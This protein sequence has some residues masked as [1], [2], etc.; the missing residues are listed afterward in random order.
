M[1]ARGHEF[2]LRVFNSISHGLGRHFQARGHSFSQYGPPSRQLEYMYCPVRH[3][4]QGDTIEKQLHRLECR[5]LVTGKGT[6]CSK[7]GWRYPPD[8][9]L[10]SG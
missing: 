2:Y 6:G 9:S 5:S 7:A 8:K 4:L 10:S 1:P 3:L